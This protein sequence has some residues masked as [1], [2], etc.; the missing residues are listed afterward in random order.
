MTNGALNRGAVISAGSVAVVLGGTGTIVNDGHIIGLGAGI[1]LG[2]GAPNATVI[3][4][5][6]CRRRQQPHDGE[7]QQRLAAAALADDAEGLPRLQRQVDAIDGQRGAERQAEAFD[8]Q[9]RCGQARQSVRAPS[10][11][12]SADCQAISQCANWPSRLNWAAVWRHT[13]SG[14]MTSSA[15]PAATCAWQARSR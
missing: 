8:A 12:R 4:R 5:D 6:P 15:L 3:N 9:Q 11:I 1:E 14:G 2:S 7:R 10:I 13:S